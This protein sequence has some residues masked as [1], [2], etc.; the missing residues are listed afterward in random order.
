MNL[1]TLIYYMMDSTEGVDSLKVS[2]QN[3]QHYSPPLP[4]RRVD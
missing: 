2:K 3:L 4:P 1:N